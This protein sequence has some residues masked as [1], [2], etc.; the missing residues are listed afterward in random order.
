MKKLEAR[1]SNSSRARPVELWSL[2]KC[3]LW[4]RILVPDTPLLHY[5]FCIDDR[6]TLFTASSSCLA[7]YSLFLHSI[8]WNYTMTTVLSTAAE[9][10]PSWASFLFDAVT[11]LPRTEN[12][13]FIVADDTNSNGTAAGKEPTDNILMSMELFPT[14]LSFCLMSCLIKMQA[15]G[16]VFRGDNAFVWGVSFAHAAATFVASD[17][18]ATKDTDFRGNNEERLIKEAVAVAKTL[19]YK[20]GRWQG[21]HS[22]GRWIQRR[23]SLRKAQEWF[24]CLSPR[25]WR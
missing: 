14:I 9:D 2:L 18:N 5:Y 23:W 16:K 15:V 19:F 8:D 1:R 7:C 4:Y 22:V 25:T 24:F 21:V 11:L 3:I 13:D 6:L 12:K 10:E 17:E 20:R